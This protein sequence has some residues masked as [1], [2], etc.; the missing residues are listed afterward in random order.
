MDAAPERPQAIDR[1]PETAS[2][3]GEGTS[4]GESTQAVHLMID[5][6][7]RYGFLLGGLEMVAAGHTT[8]EAVLARAR[9]K[10]GD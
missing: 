8:A 2:T 9:E 3:P 1:T 6:A 4:Q 5:Y 7:T 10:Y